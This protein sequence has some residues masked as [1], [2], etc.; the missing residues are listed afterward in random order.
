MYGFIFLIKFTPSLFRF[1]KTTTSAV[2]A[3]AEQIDRGKKCLL[4]YT[5]YVPEFCLKHTFKMVK[6]FEVDPNDI[7]F[8]V[9]ETEKVSDV[10]HLKSIFNTYKSS[11]MKVALDDGGT[12]FS[13][14]EMLT[15]LPPDYVKVDRSYTQNCHLN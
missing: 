15:H 7:I 4:P 2:Q 9:V 8:E 14:L 12:G 5:I 3:Q 11:G 1:P 10:N 13:T 6:E